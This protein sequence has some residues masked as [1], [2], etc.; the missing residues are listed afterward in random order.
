MCHAQSV[1]LH[2]MMLPIIEAP[3]VGIHKVRNTFLRHREKSV[4][5]TTIHR[6]QTR[7]ADSDKVKSRVGK[8]ASVRVKRRCHSD[9]L[10]REWQYDS[11]VRTEQ[12]G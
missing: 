4:P 9:L 3:Y 8:R 2:G 1:W 6:M 5:D 11:N 12:I 10:F 7:F